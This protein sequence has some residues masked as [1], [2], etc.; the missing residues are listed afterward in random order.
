MERES[1]Y[2]CLAVKTQ[3]SHS[4][5]GEQQF[6]PTRDIT[7]QKAW[8]SLLQEGWLPLHLEREPRC[9]SQSG[10]K[11]ISVLRHNYVEDLL[12]HFP[13]AH[14]RNPLHPT[15][16]S[17]SFPGLTLPSPTLSLTNTYY[18]RKIRK[19]YN[20]LPSHRLPLCRKTLTVSTG[21]RPC[22]HF[23]KS[24]PSNRV[25]DFLIAH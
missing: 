6:A 15:H 2:G 18:P 5:Q 19:K 24:R 21:T 13:V 3:E 20:V 9:A 7:K 11:H 8:A 16:H 1:P 4:L 23:Q 17:C 10:T 22:Q 12:Q 14:C 25:P